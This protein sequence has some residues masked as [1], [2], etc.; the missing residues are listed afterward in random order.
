[1]PRRPHP[2]A[3]AAAVTAAALASAALGGPAHAAPAED[4]YYPA[5]GDPGVDV[6][7]YDLDLTWLPASRRLVGDATLR[8]VTATDAASLPLDLHA[9]LTVRSVTVDG[10]ATPYRHAGKT[11]TVRAPVLAGTAYDVRVRY[12]GRPRTVAAPTSRVDTP[13]L[14]WHTTPDGRSWTVQKP[15]GAST[16]YP[17]ND[18]PSD[19]ARYTIEVTVPE[20]WTGVAGGTME[21][22]TTA[23]GL[24]TTRFT[25]AEPVS[26][27]LVTLATGPFRKYTQTG[28]RGL[29]LTYWVPRDGAAA[30]VKPLQRTP[31]ALAWLEQRLGPLPWDRAGVVVTP[32]TG[33]V[34]SATMLTLTRDNYRY[35]AADVREQVVHLLAHQWYGASTAPADWK[36]LWLAEGVPTY[37]QARYAVAQGWDTWGAVTREWARNDQYW[38][39]VYGP[40]GAYH[41]GE[42]GQRNVHHGSALMLERL[43]TRIGAAGFDAAVRDFA[44]A[45]LHTTRG[46]A[47]FVDH[48]ESRHGSLGDFWARWL[49]GKDSPA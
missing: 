4:S 36:D 23:K 45:H 17:V 6:R 12:V 40:P 14:G 13:T 22:R 46:R 34:E 16:W 30:L 20:G 19:P 15:Y 25:Q 7:T 33:S 49:N 27:H 48:V 32:G 41:A 10:V 31:Q 42:F 5:H 28:P 3:L 2:L 18:A 8:L 37:L 1:M 11:L 29:P 24:T 38:R 43:R 26:P 44:Q 39:D 47:A 35:G 9:A 21:S